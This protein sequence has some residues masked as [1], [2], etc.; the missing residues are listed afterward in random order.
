MTGGC[1]VSKRIFATALLLFIFAIGYLVFSGMKEA[2]AIPIM[3]TATINL[4]PYP[5]NADP[6]RIAL[7]SDIHVGNAVMDR[8]KLDSI[9]SAVNAQK[10]DLILLAG[11]FIIGESAKGAADRAIQLQQLRSLRAKQG[12]IAV[13]GNHDHWTD[14]VAVR[15]NL[16]QAN[17][18]IL[19][20]QAVRFGPL[21]IMGVGDRFSG[22]DDI[23]RASKEA[24][25]LGGIPIVL[26][27]SPDIAQVLPAQVPLLLA[28]HTHCGQ[29]IFPI[30]GQVVRYSHGKRLND[31]KY[32]CGRIDET[33]RT[34]I[35]TGGVGSGALPIRINTVP[36]WWMI[37]I[38]H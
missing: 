38:T 31:P 17:V 30:I 1:K 2:D 5:D 15:S 4:N 37:T 27:H 9:I 29:M 36:D 35:V 32:Q 26:S 34:V 25:E 22:H 23:E 24:G 3:R 6:V 12:V 19:E 16:E 13:L 18:L 7:L 33:G 14:M 20:N 21:T 10:P 28:G 8:S 11:D